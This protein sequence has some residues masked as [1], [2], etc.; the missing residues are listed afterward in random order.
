MMAATLSRSISLRAF[1]AKVGQSLAPSSLTGFDLPAHHAAAGVDLVDGHLFGVDQRGLGNRDGAGQR[2]QESELDHLL[3]VRA[4]WCQCSRAC[5]AQYESGSP[6][7]Y[8][9]AAIELGHGHTPRHVVAYAEG[10]AADG[11][12]WNEQIPFRRR[13]IPQARLRPGRSLGLLKRRKARPTKRKRARP[14]LIRFG[15]LLACT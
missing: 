5:D 8:E 14:G 7:L 11:V 3:S 2:V 15:P 10:F 1:S 9:S 13:T 4:A 12:R 6:R